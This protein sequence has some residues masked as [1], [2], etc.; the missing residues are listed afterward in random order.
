MA[1]KLSSSHKAL[2][3]PFS[4]VSMYGRDHPASSKVAADTEEPERRQKV[5][6]GGVR[7]A[8]NRSSRA[9]TKPFSTTSPRR[10]SALSTA[11]SS[12]TGKQKKGSPK[13]SKQT[14]NGSGRNG[15]VPRT[16]PTSERSPV[17][18]IVQVD[19]D[20][21]VLRSGRSGR[22]HQFQHRNGAWKH[23]KGLGKKSSLNPSK[24]ATKPSLSSASSNSAVASKS[25]L[26]QSTSTMSTSEVLLSFSRGLKKS[27][28]VDCSANVQLKK[29]TVNVHLPPHMH[30][31][32][33]AFGDG[34]GGK[35]VKGSSKGRPLTIDDIGMG[36]GKMQYRNVI[37]MSG[38]GVSTTSGIPDFRYINFKAKV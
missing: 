7:A 33:R 12:G 35:A 21:P 17:G 34:D 4:H 20:S 8:S 18:G 24:A 14:R 10:S 37:V 15:N 2:E 9:S 19:H 28:N 13:A 32:R 38:A 30:L 27:G 6:A 29:T 36:L 25:L 22:A 1:V 16:T 31:P 3:S 26:A 11:T 23:S 5:K